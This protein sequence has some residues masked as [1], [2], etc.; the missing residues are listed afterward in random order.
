MVIINDMS[1]L[2]PHRQLNVQMECFPC[3]LRQVTIA[4]RLVDAPRDLQESVLKAC[5]EDIASTDMD[6]TPAHLTTYMHRRVRAMLG[7][8]PFV[9][10]K[11]RY[12]RLAL[13]M[14]D[15][16]KREVREHAL[17][18]QAAAR[19]AIAGN[20][21]DFGIFTSVNVEGTARRAL[22]E[23]LAIDHFAEFNRALERA[24]KVL[25][26]LDNTGEVVFDRILIEELLAM[27]KQVVA[28]TRGAPII[29]D[30]TLKDAQ[31]VGL[32][33]ICTVTDNG[34]DAVGTILELASPEFNA[35]FDDSSYMVVSKGQ[36]NF[37]TLLSVEREVFFLFQSK[38]EV[39]SRYLSQ[40]HGALMLA[41]SRI[42]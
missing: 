39:V 12:N 28:V 5:L 1:A 11:E 19:L 20:C 23:P 27:G 30:C 36:G 15:E 14:Y 2:P 26:L 9:E 21:I 37:E 8:D 7:G 16:F 32:A 40:P 17:P 35:L 13:G 3:F 34:S 22:D 41:S 29:N 6:K 24:D 10:V 18:L 42:A 38:C 25:Y 33:D 31:D 4:L